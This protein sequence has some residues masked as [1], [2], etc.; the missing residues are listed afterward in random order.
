M[1]PLLGVPESREENCSQ[2]D[3]D[4][5]HHQH[6]QLRHAV[7]PKRIAPLWRL[8]GLRATVHSR[9]AVGWERSNSLDTAFLCQSGL[10]SLSGTP[11]GLQ[12]AHYW[13]AVSGSKPCRCTG[14]PFS[15]KMAGIA[16]RGRSRRR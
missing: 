16:N 14:E 5:D 3:D 2:N 1:C 15:G 8:M 7:N 11:E 9:R 12:G 13:Q 10:S 4:G 6:W